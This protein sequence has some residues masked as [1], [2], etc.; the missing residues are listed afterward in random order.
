[1]SIFNPNQPPIFDESKE[2][3]KRQTT[4][5]TPMRVVYPETQ[6]SKI[7]SEIEAGRRR[8]FESDGVLGL[9]ESSEDAEYVARIM[10]RL[11][12][13][14]SH[15]LFN[16]LASGL[17]SAYTRKETFAEEP[18]QLVDKETQRPVKTVFTLSHEGLFKLML[19]P[20]VNDKGRA[21]SGAG[22]V[23]SQLK[24]QILPILRG[25]E[26][27]PI[28]C[29]SIQKKGKDGQVIEAA[30]FGK[31]IVIDKWTSNAVRIM[32]DHYFFP[33][34]ESDTRAGDKY[35]NQVA[36][37]A[38]FLNFGRYLLRQTG[39]GGFPQ[40]PDAHKLILSVQAAFEM[41]GFAP[42]IVRE[43]SIG[44]HNVIF[45]RAAIKDLR[46]EAIESTG[47]PNFRA[48]SDFVSNVGQMYRAA[49]DE[50]GIEDQLPANVLIPATEKGAEFPTDQRV[51]FVK[52][53]RKK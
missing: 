7:A 42:G 14:S 47:R 15:I 5:I 25:E 18:R 44:R 41:Q 24:D 21:I 34:L 23:V 19:G 6:R 3:I 8:A 17:Y 29:S 50:T 9:V 35:L 10:A 46:P 1:M 33:I 30:V 39:K 52:V 43:N 26:V 32:L 31:P 4:A 22:P 16:D 40:T 11:K 20:L 27:E 53:D 37:L 13:G 12:Y 48:F 45:R 49:L 2:H 36:G 51:V 38:A 28:A